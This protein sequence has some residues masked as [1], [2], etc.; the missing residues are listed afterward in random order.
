MYGNERDGINGGGNRNSGGRRSC[1]H[2]MR[3]EMNGGESAGVEES[4]KPQ[5]SE[6]ISNQCMYRFNGS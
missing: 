4:G 3:S 6:N 5:S 2:Q 1:H